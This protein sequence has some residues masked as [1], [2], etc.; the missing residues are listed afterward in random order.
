MAH[1]H[2]MAINNGLSAPAATT[3]RSPRLLDASR[4]QQLEQRIQQLRRRC[5]CV[6]G[7]LTT[8]SSLFYLGYFIYT[9]H[10]SLLL[11]IVWA[12]AGFILSMTVGLLAKVMALAF[13]R[14]HIHY[15]QRKL[16]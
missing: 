5:G 3:Q 14:M 4:R 15:L 11:S 7:A 16:R 2:N 6:S 10:Y 12:I 8:L 1:S 13:T 9:R